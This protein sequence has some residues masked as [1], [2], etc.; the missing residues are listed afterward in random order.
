MF[1]LYI[2]FTLDESSRKLSLSNQLNL[3]GL[4]STDVAET[5]PIYTDNF[6]TP[7]IIFIIGFILGDGTLPLRLRNSDKGYIW[8]ISTLLLSMLNNKYNAPQC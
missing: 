5:P 3:L 2:L 4:N 8:L 1:L 6:T 7:L